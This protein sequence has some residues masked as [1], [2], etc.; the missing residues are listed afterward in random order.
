MA[1]EI[2]LQLDCAQDRRSLAPEEVEMRKQLKGHC[3]GLASLER[4]ISRQRSRITYLKEGDANTKFFH[5][6]A[7]YRKRKNHIRVLETDDVRTTTHEGMAD[8]LK[9]YFEHLLGR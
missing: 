3:L 6:H 7:S 2:I 5:L 8:I 4:T 1:N 9:E